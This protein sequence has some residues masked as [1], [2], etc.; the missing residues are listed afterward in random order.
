VAADADFRVGRGR[1]VEAP[2]RDILMLFAG[3]P[4]AI[5]ADLSP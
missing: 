1:L 5:N 4:A 3:R 2:M